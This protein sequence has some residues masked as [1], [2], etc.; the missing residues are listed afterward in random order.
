M[1]VTDW[2]ARIDEIITVLTKAKKYS[3]KEDYE[4]AFDRV[5][6]ASELLEILHNDMD[7]I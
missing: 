7:K 2:E 5:A 4:F 3:K 6:S 1:F